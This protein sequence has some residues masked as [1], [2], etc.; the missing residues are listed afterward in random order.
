M[1]LIS[2]ATKLGSEPRT[3]VGRMVRYLSVGLLLCTL[4]AI[5]SAPTEAAAADL[6]GDSAR[7]KPDSFKPGEVIVKYRETAGGKRVNNLDLQPGRLLNSALAQPYKLSSFK[8][9]FNLPGYYIYNASPQADMG[10]LVT[11]LSLD[12][13]VE[14][15]EPN[16]IVSYKTTGAS[17]TLYNQTFVDSNGVDQSRQYYIKKLGIDALWDSSIGNNQ[18]IAI[19]DTGVNPFH[20]DLLD[21]VSQDH[22]YDFINGRYVTS[23]PVANQVIWDDEG[24][25]TAIAGIIAAQ[26][27]N[28]LGIAGINWRSILISVKVLDANGVG[29]TTSVGQGIVF[30][31]D[32]QARIINLSLGSEQNSKLLEGAVQ[33]AQNKG[34]LLVA[35]S[36]NSPNGKPNYPGAF[37]GVIAVAATDLND[38]IASFSSYGT[39]VSVAAPG[40]EIFTTYCNFLGYPIGNSNSAPAGDYYDVVTNRVYKADTSPTSVGGHRPDCVNPNPTRYLQPPVE[41][42]NKYTVSC[43]YTSPSGGVSGSVVTSRMYLYIDGTSFAAPIVTGIVSLGI[44]IR[45]DMTNAQI[46]T[47]LESTSID[48]DA[49]GRDN[50]SGYGRVNAAAFRDAV[51][52]GNFTGGRLSVLQ[53]IV[54]GANFADVLMNL[55][56]PNLNKNLDNNGGFRYEGLGSGVYQ[57]RLAIPKRGIVLGPIAVYPNGRSDNVLSVNF[58]V[59]SGSIICGAGT[60]CPGSQNSAPG[61]PVPIPIGPTSPLAPNSGSFAAAAPLPGAVFF[62]E[63]SHNLSGAFRAY[64]ETKGGLAVFGFAVSEEF[65][66]V[67]QTDGRTYTVQY[68]QRNRFEFHPEKNDP[69]KVLLG[70]L[71]SELTRGRTFAPGAPVPNTSTTQYFPE[72]QHTLSDRFLAYWNAKGGLAIF[73][74]PISEPLQEGGLLVQYFERNR[75]EYHPEN[76]GTQYEVLLGLLGIDLARNRGYIR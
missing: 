70:L 52:S 18:V 60:V 24:H 72:T 68:F 51:V 32:N 12:P 62:P 76:G 67:S 29:T 5:F 40:K 10:K 13:T 56:P 49:P 42:N 17:D 1:K 69:N 15:A 28:K 33:Y 54:T 65:S 21:K 50:R 61:Q 25:G 2:S 73:G 44:A 66:E 31:A 45:P 75:F 14:F 58:D 41:C 27:D 57:L 47:V 8:E 20:E 23:V 16:Y 6:W 38:K 9:L 26:T 19:L 4:M 71:G 22:S 34:V 43:Y 36:G 64:W 7:F 74:Y 55:D 35:A 30:A 59:A 48:I 11:A 37:P 39:Y 3:R 53:G 63:T 46:K